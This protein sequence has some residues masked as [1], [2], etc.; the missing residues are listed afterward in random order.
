MDTPPARG[1]GPLVNRLTYA[2]PTLVIATFIVTAYL[3]T[4]GGSQMPFHVVLAYLLF[5]AMCFHQ[6]EEYVWPA[7]FIWA[8]NRFHGSDIPDRYPGNRLSVFLVDIG[9]LIAGGY[10][11]F[12]KPTPVITAIFAIFA[13]VEVVVHT[14]FGIL[15]YREF[16]DRGKETIYFPGNATAWFLFAPLGLAACHELITERLLSGT[17]WLIAA[18]SVVLFILAPVVAATFLL[19]DRNTVFVYRTRPI[20]GYFKRY[21]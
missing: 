15:T 13:V 11:L 6:L 7:G 12:L 5:A 18:G 2:H 4:I 20:E 8:F 9:S 19:A 21:L 10:F 16:R 14:L 17:G 3:L 1:L